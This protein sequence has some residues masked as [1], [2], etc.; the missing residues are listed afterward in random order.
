MNKC[1]AFLLKKKKKKKTELRK[2]KNAVQF[3]CFAVGTLVSYLGKSEF[4]VRMDPKIDEMV[5][6]LECKE[7]LK[8]LGEADT[9]S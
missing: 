4:Y 6:K 3:K 1:L 2:S 8:K 5:A 7:D 9:P